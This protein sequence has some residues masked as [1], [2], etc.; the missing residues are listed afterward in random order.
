MP[1]RAPV[2]VFLVDDHEV[3]R[4]GIR[5][6][7]EAEPDLTVIGD[8]GTADEALAQLR[9]CTP[10]VA[11]LDV[12]LGDGNGNG[13]DVCRAVRRDHPTVECLMLS[14]FAD[15]ETIGASVVAGAVGYVVK[16]IRGRELVESI[17]AAAD[18]R[19]LHDPLLLAR[20]AEQRRQ[21]AE[22]DGR[23]D[24]LTAQEHRIL[25]GL[26]AGLT[27]RQIAED[28]FLAEKTVKNYVS[29]VLMKLGMQRRTEAAVY[30]SRHGLLVDRRAG[31]GPASM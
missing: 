12:Q 15:E 30:A 20:V 3:V 2:E 7:I 5:D 23:L 16:D 24:S 10:D 29:N 21:H 8:A 19:S 13:I 6:L 28:L 1:R 14:S 4:R 17:R 9:G 22:G 25:E 11:V 18:G 27:N 31:S 26:A